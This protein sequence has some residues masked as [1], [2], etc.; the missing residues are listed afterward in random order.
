MAVSNFKQR[1]ES[2]LHVDG[3]FVALVRRIGILDSV[4]CPFVCVT[5]SLWYGTPPMVR[6]SK[7]AGRSA[8]TRSA[9]VPAIAD[10]AC[11]PISGKT[12]VRRRRLFDD[13]QSQ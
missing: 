5:M 1:K 3:L 9:L 11:N 12:E 10:F 7:A 13:Q 2:S 4:E 6:K 8:L